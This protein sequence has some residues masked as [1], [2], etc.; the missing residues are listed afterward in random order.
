MDLEPSLTQYFELYRQISL[1]TSER[2]TED[3]LN[4]YAKRLNIGKLEG[5]I[6]EILH[7]LLERVRIEYLYRWSLTLDQ[8]IT[9]VAELNSLATSLDIE[10]LSGNISDIIKELQ[11]E[12]SDLYREYILKYTQIYIEVPEIRKRNIVTTSV[13]PCQTRQ[14]CRAQNST[15]MMSPNS[16]KSINSRLVVA[17]GDGEEEMVKSLLAEGATDLD[18]AMIKAAKYGK[19]N[20]VRLLINEGVNEGF[21]EAMIKAAKNGHV[22]IVQL[23]INEGANDPEAM[24]QAVLKDH[25]SVV[26]V[27]E[28]NGITLNDAMIKAVSEKRKGK[29][30]L[31][32]ENGANNLDQALRIASLKGYKSIAK[33]LLKWGASNVNDSLIIAARAGEKDIVK[34]MIKAGSKRIIK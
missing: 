31:L 17:S 24:I 16:L 10:N 19:E 26:T 12:A 7:I 25:K 4:F 32:Y 1:H 8:N 22:N 3:E 11:K 18:E 2:V 28:Q 9:N 20:I 5:T 6:D 21:N 15:S 29:A 14:T 30:K 13:S 23:M 34:L 27:L 33:S